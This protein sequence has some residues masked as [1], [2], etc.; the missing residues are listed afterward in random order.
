MKMISCQAPGSQAHLAIDA[1][2]CVLHMLHTEDIGL[3]IAMLFPA[4]SGSDVGQ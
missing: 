4:V 3:S 1:G 2:Y